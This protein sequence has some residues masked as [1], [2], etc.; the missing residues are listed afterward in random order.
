MGFSGAELSGAYRGREVGFEPANGFQ[1]LRLVECARA[2]TSR[3]AELKVS[4]RCLAV[5]GALMDDEESVSSLG[6]FEGG[7]TDLSHSI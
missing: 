5:P 2:N 1:P 6:R 4:R 7:M 3:S